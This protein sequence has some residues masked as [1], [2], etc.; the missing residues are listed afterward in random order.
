MTSSKTP[1][2]A[3]KSRK[4]RK[5]A[6]LSRLIKPE[7]MSIEEWQIE[8]RRQFGQE[9][10]FKLSNLGEEPVFSDFEVVNPASGC[11]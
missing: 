1:K 5:P 7:K 9:Q 2:S 11:R 3:A 10:N 4:K 8:L 6:K